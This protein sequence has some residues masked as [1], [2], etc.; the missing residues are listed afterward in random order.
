MSPATPSEK[1]EE[2]FPR[3]SLSI[4][5]DDEEDEDELLNS[6]SSDEELQE[7]VMP[8]KIKKPEGVTQRLIQQLDE[9]TN[10][11][12]LV[13]VWGP[14]VEFIVR[15]MLVATFLD[16]SF[17]TTTHISEQTLQV[18]ESGC[19]KWLAA[20]SPMLAR[21]IATV[22]L[23]ISVFAQLL[24]SLSLLVQ[25]WPN[26]ATIALIGWLIFQPVLYGQ[27]SNMEFVSG[28]LSLIGGLLML[29]AHLVSE[30]S[31]RTALIGRLLLPAMYVYYAGKSL[32]SAVTLDVTDGLSMY[33]ASLSEF[34]VNVAIVFGIA[35]GS[36]LVTVGLKS[37]FV[38]LVLALVNLGFIFFL[39][40]FFRFV[41]FSDGE[42]KY[43]ER[44]PVP[45]IATSTDLI[46]DLPQI[47]D[48]HKYYFFL[49]LST[50]G[51]LLLLARFGPGMI[52]VQKDEV[53]LPV[54]AR[55]QD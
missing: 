1:Y 28:S 2:R 12:L 41:W 46:Y 39:H 9:R 30:H 29:R 10:I 34:F 25:R 35:I 26:G 51:A 52:A 50:S 3:Q 40:P 17:R 32:C 54:V 4:T 43:D 23:L 47:Y 55:A 49:G 31:E 14:R 27:F 15:L 19:L 16:D 22:V 38:A 18:G 20:T 24:G 33:L 44:M 13:R 6:A 45:N 53:L 8:Y 37:R 48:L 11:K 5:E 7:L 42:W 21:S 36:M